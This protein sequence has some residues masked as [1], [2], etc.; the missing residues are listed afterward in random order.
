DA[1]LDF[2]LTRQFLAV[3]PFPLNQPLSPLLGRLARRCSTAIEAIDPE[4]ISNAQEVNFFDFDFRL[5]VHLSGLSGIVKMSGY[6]VCHTAQMR[7]TLDCY[8][9]S[10]PRIGRQRL[11]SCSA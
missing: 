1:F 2:L 8:A 6:Q 7:H 9:R 4:A 10:V 5:S 11:G 3:Q